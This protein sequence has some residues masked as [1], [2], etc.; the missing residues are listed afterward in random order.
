MIKWINECLKQDCG[1]QTDSQYEK[2]AATCQDIERLLHTLWER[3][4]DI[5]I[6]R[7]NRVTVH[8]YLLILYVSGCRPGMLENIRWKDFR[9]YLLPDLDEPDRPRLFAD[10]TLWFNKLRRKVLVKSDRDRY[11]TIYMRKVL[12][13]YISSNLTCS[14]LHLFDD[15]DAH[16]AP[17]P[18]PYHRR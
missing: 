15:L 4:D 5:P 6:P 7:Q 3:A 1:L 17:G 2:V 8:L 13:A 12:G 16:P 14:Q 18:N 11:V 10:L 9:L